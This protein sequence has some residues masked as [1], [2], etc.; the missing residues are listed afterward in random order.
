MTAEVAFWPARHRTPQRRV[1]VIFAFALIT[2]GVVTNARLVVDSSDVI[3]GPGTALRPLDAPIDA[4]VCAPDPSATTTTRVP[5]R[6]YVAL[7]LERVD[8]RV[9]EFDFQAGVYYGLARLK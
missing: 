8:V 4:F 1:L 5:G 6:R 2:L 3:C 9:F 7:F